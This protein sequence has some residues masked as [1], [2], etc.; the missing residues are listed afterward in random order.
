ML[1][2]SSVRCADV[3]AVPQPVPAL[4]ADN[5]SAYGGNIHAVL[6]PEEKADVGHGVRPAADR[7]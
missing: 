1:S 5:G 3:H 2:C 7:G 6:L 4:R